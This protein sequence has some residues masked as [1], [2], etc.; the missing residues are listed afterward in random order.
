MV[1]TYW[2][3]GLPASGKT[4]LG[5][6]LVS[7]LIELAHTAVLLDGDVIRAGL[8]ADLGFSLDDRT[9]NIRRVAQIAKIL[10]AQ[11]IDVVCSLVSPLASQRALVREILED[12]VVIV[13][14]DCPVDVCA[15][16]DPKGLWASAAAGE[17]PDWTGVGQR[18]EPPSSPDHHYLSDKDSPETAAQRI[19]QSLVTHD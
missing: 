6:T 10:N 14:V 7:R 18:Y 5:K 13:F 3:T 1:K 17:I 8:C 15:Q 2:L 11:G 16:R 9:E 12:S 19:L 4:T